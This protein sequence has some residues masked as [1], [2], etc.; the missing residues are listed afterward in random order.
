MLTSCTF[1][2]WRVSAAQSAAEKAVARAARHRLVQDVS[3]HTPGVWIWCKTRSIGT[4]AQLNPKPKTL[5]CPLCGQHSVLGLMT[6]T[7]LA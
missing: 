5:C 6:I 1:L 2:S 4:S 3:M 7:Y